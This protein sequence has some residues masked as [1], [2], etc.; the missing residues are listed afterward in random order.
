VY[1]RSKTVRALDR[2]AIE[3]G[4]QIC[5]IFNSQA[6]LNSSYRLKH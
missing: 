3:T 1:E 6:F 5:I 4:Q 2:T